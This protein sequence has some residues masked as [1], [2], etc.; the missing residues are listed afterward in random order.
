VLLS[1]LLC[2]AGAGLYL[3]AQSP[4]PAQ[5]TSTAGESYLIIL[6]TQDRAPTLWAGG[7]KITG[8]NLLDMSIWRRGKGDSV[9]L[10]KSSFAISTRK[11]SNRVGVSSRERIDRHRRAAD[12]RH[13]FRR[14][15]YS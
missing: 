9:N 3:Y 2:L 5:I 10:A 12:N 14:W 7:I 8:S 1:L 15:N 13:H 4:Q 6:G 11:I